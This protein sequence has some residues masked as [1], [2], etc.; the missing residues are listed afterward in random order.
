MQRVLRT[1]KKKFTVALP[2]P[3]AV[4][5]VEESADDYLLGRL[6]GASLRAG[7]SAGVVKIHDPKPRA[8]DLTLELLETY[9]RA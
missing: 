4:D 9:S 8:L 5:A 6:L 3:P 2:P 7:V 1:T